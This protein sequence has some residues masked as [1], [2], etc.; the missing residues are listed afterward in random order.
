MKKQPE[1]NYENA[2]KWDLGSIFSYVFRLAK[3]IVIAVYCIVFLLD[4][5]S[6]SVTLGDLIT[7][8]KKIEK[9]SLW[10]K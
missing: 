3:F 1:F 2:E 6:Q 9:S 8:K 5:A 4:I 10:E 7:P